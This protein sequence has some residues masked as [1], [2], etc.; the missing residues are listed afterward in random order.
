M[1]QKFQ[2][3]QFELRPGARQL[4]AHGQ[5]LPVGGRAF[6]VLC[7]L[8]S[9]RDRVVGKSELLG[10]AWPGRVVE[11]NNLTVQVSALRKLLGPAAIATVAAY[12]YRFTLPVLVLDDARPG[13]TDTTGLDDGVLGQAAPSAMPVLLVATAGAQP[14]SWLPRALAAGVA[15]HGGH[16]LD[17]PGEACVAAFASAR[18]ATAC[19]L[20]LQAAARRDGHGLRIALVPRS[21]EPLPD[22]QAAPARTDLALALE[23]AD[24]APLGG[25]LAAA[26]VR[27]QVTDTLD[28]RIEDLG[29]LPLRSS[30]AAL[31]SYRVEPHAPAASAPEVLDA[32][33]MKPLVAIVPFEA[34]QSSGT[35]LAI[36]ELIADGL[37]SLFG[38][39]RHTWR[40]VSRLSASA[41]RGRENM[42]GDVQRHLGAAYI[43]SGS[44]VELPTRLLITLQVVDTRSGEVVR[45]QRLDGALDDLLSLRSALLEAMF[46]EVQQAV[47]EVELRR[48]YSAPLPTLQSYSLLLGGIQLLHRSTPRD[49]D[50]SFR[51]LGQLAQTHPHALEPRVWQAKWYAMRAVQGQANDLSADAKAALACTGAALAIDPNNAFALAMEGFVHTHLT[52]D[53]ST[54]RERLEGAILQNDSET[55][56][57]LFHGVVEGLCGNFASG[58]ASYEVALSTSPQ[59]PARYLMDSIGAYLYLGC[60]QQEPAIRLAKESLRHNRNH[61]HTWRIITIG[62]QE[63]GALQEA[64]QSLQRV[65][66]LQPDLTVQRYVAGARPGD[67]VR[68]RFAEALARA[69][70]P[71]H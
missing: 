54:A 60:G 63:S 41:F 65:L 18:A 62:Q 32:S 36:G 68:H 16:L 38:H 2:F 69:G 5:A 66:E 53:Y 67:P 9:H 22:G 25:T 58:L 59:D 64:R 44:Y 35:S 49:F 34:R 37:I 7:A 70:L 71:M 27:D 43:V 31:R 12:G 45:V 39:A 47:H 15:R 17:S 40:V 3:H 11:E 57:H 51:V 61:A 13:L 1:V 8:V 48:V 46:A 10:L 20:D 19:A 56:A 42:V 29:D 30:G 23:L 21:V 28:C 6:D 55:F 26:G 33:A 14:V 52:R 24:L 50:L 4:L